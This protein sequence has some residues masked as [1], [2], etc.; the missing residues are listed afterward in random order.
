MKIIWFTL[1][2]LLMFWGCAQQGSEITQTRTGAQ[3][4]G[5]NDADV[6]SLFSDNVDEAEILAAEGVEISEGTTLN[7]VTGRRGNVIDFRS[8]T[9]DYAYY[10]PSINRS[11]KAE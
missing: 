7:L 3:T 5:L 4:D 2:A 11:Y 6:D 9:S 1:F 8:K 10:L